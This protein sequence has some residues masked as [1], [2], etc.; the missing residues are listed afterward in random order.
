MLAE[1]RIRL[2]KG[3][4]TVSNHCTGQQKAPSGCIFG[5]VHISLIYCG[6]QLVFPASTKKLKPQLIYQGLRRTGLFS[7]SS[8]IKQGILSSPH[9]KIPRQNRG[10]NNFS[11]SSVCSITV[12]SSRNLMPAIN[13]ILN[14]VVVTLKTGESN[15]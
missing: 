8:S 15:A 3:L 5:L 13:L 4:N 9:Q 7:L 10:T 1:N 6:M 2:T 12:L 14:F 11:P